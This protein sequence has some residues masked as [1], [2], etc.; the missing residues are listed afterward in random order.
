MGGYGAVRIALTFPDRYVLAM[1][2]SGAFDITRE[3]SVFG[4]RSRPDVIDVFGALGSA[5][6]QTNDVYQ[7]AS[8]A[9]PAS[10]PYLYLT[11]GAS[12]PW[13]EANRELDRALASRA[14]AHEYHE[15]AGGHDWTFWDGQLP[16]LLD[17]MRRR[18]FVN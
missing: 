10:T 12:D 16:G 14:I 18:R 5:V 3:D 6:R 4:G 9:A 17:V 7:V 13:L 8:S 1:S 2:L 15:S 11:C